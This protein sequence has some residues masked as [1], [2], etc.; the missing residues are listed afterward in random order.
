MLVC[1][2]AGHLLTKLAGPC[3]ALLCLE[4]QAVRSQEQSQARQRQPVLLQATSTAVGA[5]W[6]QHSAQM[7]A[8]LLTLAQQMQG[9]PAAATAE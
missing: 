1:S 4:Q 3:Q 5:E 8:V 6:L 2:R 7:Q 9:A